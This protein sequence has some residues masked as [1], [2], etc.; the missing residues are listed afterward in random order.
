M[1]PPFLFTPFI[2]FF[3]HFSRRKKKIPKKKQFRFAQKHGILDTE[4]SPVSRCFFAHRDALP[5][6]RRPDFSSDWNEK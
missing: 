4:T 2:C 5:F 6:L 1:L 3:R